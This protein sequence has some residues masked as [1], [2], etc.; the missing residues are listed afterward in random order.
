MTGYGPAEAPAADRAELRVLLTA[1]GLAGPSAPADALQ[2]GAAVM[3]W[4][5]R[6][7]YGI[8]LADCGAAADSESWAYARFIAAVVNAL[9]ELLDALDA[10]ERGQA[11]AHVAAARWGAYAGRLYE[12][13]RRAGLA[14]DDIPMPTADQEVE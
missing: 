3:V 13:A 6:G 14:V 11:A 2:T 9:P 7:G 4:A 5:E 10:A 1:A 12:L 8:P